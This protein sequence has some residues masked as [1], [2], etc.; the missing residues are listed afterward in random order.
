MIKSHLEIK[1]IE[2]EFIDDIICNNCGE[3]CKDDQNMNY[4]GLIEADV[5]GGYAS[6]LGDLVHY[7]FSICEKCLEKMFKGF[8]IQPDI[9][10]II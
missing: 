7:K 10:R 4:E 8:K 1:E 9:R 5:N 2:E 3:S 6:L